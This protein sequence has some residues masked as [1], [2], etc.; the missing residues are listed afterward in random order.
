MGRN[1][2]EAL[3]QAGEENEMTNGQIIIRGLDC[4]E[5]NCG[6]YVD[7]WQDVYKC[8][9]GCHTNVEFVNDEYRTIR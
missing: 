8:G 1:T 4:T 9:C 3:V 2:T 5:C 7:T 6:H